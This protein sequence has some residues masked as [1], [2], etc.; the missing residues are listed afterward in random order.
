[1]Q[2]LFLGLVCA[3]TVPAVEI[4]LS[5]HPPAGGLLGPYRMVLDLELASG[6]TE[7]TPAEFAA[8]EGAQDVADMLARAYGGSK[9]TS[10]QA[11]LRVY[12][13]AYDGSPVKKLTIEST[14]PKPRVRWVLVP[15][16]KK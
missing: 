4:D 6:L 1:M 12:L 3:V 13:I 5:A 15:R 8:S 11:G 7:S 2:N 10:R 9:W 16:W 14:G